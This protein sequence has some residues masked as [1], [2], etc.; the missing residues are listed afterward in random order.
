[1]GY[2][3][4]TALYTNYRNDII[5]LYIGDQLI[6]TTDNHPFYVEDKGWVFAD[7]L[8]VG[9]KLQKADGSNLTIDKVEFVLLD[10]PVMVYNFTVADYHTYYVTDLGIW[11]PGFKP[12][13]KGSTGRTAPKNNTELTSMQKAMTDP[14]KGTILKM[15]SLMQDKRWK[16][17]DGWVKMSRTIKGVEIHWV[18]NI[19]TG[20][21]DDFKF[22]DK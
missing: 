6:E 18:Y 13:G 22:K 16:H 10:E 3:E 7:E 1:M 12:Y 15:P 19:R 4:V 20:K 9:D 2:K 21:Y 8:Q 17:S 5:K 14:K 11:V